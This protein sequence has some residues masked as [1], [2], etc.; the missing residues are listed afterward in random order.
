MSFRKD[1]L[2]LKEEDSEEGE[3]KVPDL[4]SVQGKRQNPNKGLEEA[5]ELV[6]NIDNKL[7]QFANTIRGMDKR[8]SYN[9]RLLGSVLTPS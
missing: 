6:E 1:E 4:L 8:M 5:Y 3:S 2:M 9:L 7:Y